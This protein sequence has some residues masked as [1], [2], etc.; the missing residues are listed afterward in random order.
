MDWIR[1]VVRFVVS[2]VV[3]MFVGA[4]VPGFRTL[5]FWNALLAALV[6]AGLGWLV[7]VFL[8]RNVSPYGRGI[9]GFIVSAVVIWAAQFIVPGMSVTILGALLA[10]LII[11]VVDMFVPTALR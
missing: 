1:A 8:G 11:G 6:I 10:A 2:A 7:E 9:V 3:L 4:I 5:G